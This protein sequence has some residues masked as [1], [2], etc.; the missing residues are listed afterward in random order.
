MSKSE[1]RS[2]HDQ[3]SHTRHKQHQPDDEQHMIDATEQMVHTDPEIAKCCKISGL[4][5]GQAGRPCIQ[6]VVQPL[7]LCAQMGDVDVRQSALEP[8]DC[9]RQF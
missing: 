9:D 4:A 6:E 1:H 3:G 7:A 2:R 8:L 5:E